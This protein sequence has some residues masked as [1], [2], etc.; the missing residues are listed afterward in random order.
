MD[1]QVDFDTNMAII[2]KFYTYLGNFIDV[3]EYNDPEEIE[4]LSEYLNEYDNAYEEWYQGS[5]ASENSVNGE[6]S[7]TSSD[8]ETNNYIL[9]ST[10]ST[11]SSDSSNSSILS[12]ELVEK[13]ASKDL[14]KL[15][16]KVER[17]FKD[18]SLENF[19]SSDSNI[20]NILLYKN[21][22]NLINR[23]NLFTKSVYQY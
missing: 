14:K 20:D 19:I 5:E 2:K 12:N 13:A 6:E 15:K 23:C 11:E 7:E 22:S 18:K 1:N 10:E 3:G 8:E 4:F 17:T 16:N 21:N 9:E